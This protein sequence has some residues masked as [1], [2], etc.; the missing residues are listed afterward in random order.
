MQKKGQPIRTDGPKNQ[1]PTGCI[2]NHDFTY[3]EIIWIIAM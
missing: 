2:T 1:D 3:K